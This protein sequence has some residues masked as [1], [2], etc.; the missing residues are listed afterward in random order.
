M[1]SNNYFNVQ[2]TEKPVFKVQNPP[3][4]R[5]QLDYLFNAPQEET[6]QK[7]VRFAS[8][9]NLFEERNSFG[10]KNPVSNSNLFSENSF[11]RGRE[12]NLSNQRNG[13][14][15]ITGQSHFDEDRQV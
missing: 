10:T 8:Q 2:S 5:S 6:K 13:F 1:N 14:N 7:Q 3:G 12:N 15:P 11:A 4:G 9:Q